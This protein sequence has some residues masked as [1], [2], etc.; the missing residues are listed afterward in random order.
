VIFHIATASDWRAARRTGTYTTSTRGR[1]LEQE[2]FIHCSRSEQ[3]P[4]VRERWY[5][6]VTEPLVLLAVDPE[7]LTSP[8][9]EESA[10]P[11]GETFPHVH[12]PIDVDAVVRATPLDLAL[13]DLDR[14]FTSIFVGEMV[15]RVALAMVVIVL[16]VVGAVVG[17]ALSGVDETAQARG[18][19]V[20]LVV[21]LVVGALV[22]VAWVRSG[23]TRARRTRRV[24]RG[25]PRDRPAH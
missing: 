2:G 25:D 4:A 24:R 16:A 9:V 10:D 1:T 11:G 21:G 15:R 18:A 17:G 5:A 19:A 23:P 20:G 8:V 7:K 13:A 14:S 6:D 22:V 12:G 3:W